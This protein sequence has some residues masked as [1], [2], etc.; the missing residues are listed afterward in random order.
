[1]QVLFW[2][3]SGE[4]DEGTKEKEK[5]VK[6]EEKDDDKPEATETNPKFVGKYPGNPYN[7]FQ[8]PSCPIAYNKKG[9][10]E[11]HL[12]YVHEDQNSFDCQDCSKTGFAGKELAEHIKQNHTQQTNVDCNLCSEVFVSGYQWFKHVG[13]A[14]KNTCP[15][16][17]QTLG[18][19]KELRVGGHN[20]FY[21]DIDKHNYSS[22][23]CYKCRLRF[24]DKSKL[25]K[26]V[27]TCPNF[28]C[29]FCK[30]S[31]T[32]EIAL[33][34]HV[35]FHDLNKEDKAI[36]TYICP[37]CGVEFRYK[38]EFKTHELEHTSGNPNQCHLCGKSFQIKTRLVRHL[39][40]VHYGS[41]DFLCNLCG[42]SFKEKGSQLKHER[43]VHA[44]VNNFLCPQPGCD[45]AFKAK[46]NLTGHLK[47][48]HRLGVGL[49]CVDCGRI[50]TTRRILNK[51]REKKHGHPLE[52]KVKES[53][54][55]G[56]PPG[57]VIYSAIQEG[58]TT[59]LA[60]DI[61]HTTSK[62]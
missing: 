45:K 57:G 15:A 40:N 18:D 14:H 60:R 26:H 39:K 12:Q 28:P 10:F 50:F 49:P 33:S 31:S 46:D 27:E 4:T 44:T 19:K 54:G 21:V 2:L 8:C 55:V 38:N 22:A 34:N 47:I 20:C 5:E 6:V 13:A 43:N 11:L 36:R 53:G 24:P 29:F 23:T 35:R 9:L 62:I 51:H 7:F 61:P 30:V 59:D 3:I 1:M 48:T 41:R 52:E 37:L 25:P 42:K 58:E 56:N 16:C 32:T 17:Y